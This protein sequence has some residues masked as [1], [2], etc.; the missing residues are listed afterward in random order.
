MKILGIESSGL[1]ASVAVTEGDI[2]KAEFTINNRMT[3]SET[4]LPMLEQMMKLLGEDVKEA[5]AIAVSA[6]PGSFTGL[7]IGAATAKGLGLAVNRP[8]IKVSS[9]AALGFQLNTCGP[10]T[11]VCPIMDARR[12][13][14]YCAAYQSGLEVIKE[15]ACD[16]HIFLAALNRMAEEADVEFVFL[17]DGVPVHMDVIA[18]E[19]NADFSFASAENNRQRAASVAVLGGLLYAGWLRKNG[20]TADEVRKAGADSVGC[21]DE[22]V[23]NS[24]TFV[25]EYLRKPQAER[26][27]E[28]GL[29]EDPG[30]HSLK[31]LAKGEAR[32]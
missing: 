3:H 24:D 19:L 13:Q 30:L 23:M 12:G 11:V 14:V 6:G 10:E 28:A 32:G 4:L 26:E 9:L 20:I 22:I 15:Q 7:R 5:D 18:A 8:L 29:L 16:I 17:G 1:V 25:P 21:F 27:M 31:K 2:L